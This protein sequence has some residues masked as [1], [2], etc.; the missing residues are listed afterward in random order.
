MVG[1]DLEPWDS[2]QSRAHDLFIFFM[3]APLV[4]AAFFVVMLAGGITALQ[5]IS[6]SK[7]AES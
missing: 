4:G 5:K 3:F 7:K 2:T 6:S 1:I